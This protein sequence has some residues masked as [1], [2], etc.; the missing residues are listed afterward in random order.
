MPKF[1]PL[2][3]SNFLFGTRHRPYAMRAVGL[4][5]LSV[6]VEFGFHETIAPCM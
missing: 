3:I 5:L 6:A 1:V 2:Q 4:R